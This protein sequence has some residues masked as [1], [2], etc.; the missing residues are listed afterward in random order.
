MNDFGFTA[1]DQVKT[2]YKGLS[3]VVILGAGAS[4]ASVCDNPEKNGKLLPS[5]DNLIDI[6]GLEGM[7]SSNI[8]KYNSRNFELLF[9]SLYEENK[10]SSLIKDLETEVYNYFDSLSLPDTPTIYDYLILSLRSKDIIATFNWD[11]FLWQAFVRNMDFTDNLPKL[12]FLHGNVAV[13]V[14]EEDKSFGPK[15]KLSNKSKKPFLP[16]K[17]L[18][19]ITKKDYA[20]N[21]YIADQWNLL[22]QGLKKPAR[23][24][25]FGYSAP[26]SDVEAIKIMKKAY[27]NP[28]NQRFTQFEIIDI[29][30]RYELADTWNEFI[31]SHHYEVYN[32]FFDSTI[33]RFPRRT[34]EVFW[35]NYMQAK[36]WAPNNPPRVNKLSELWDWYS[37]FLPAEN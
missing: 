13:G 6:I 19:P 10:D 34:G 37:K 12:A 2:V 35:E 30:D 17:L 3:H 11:P 36:W 29:K 5:M 7:L 28:E 14:C 27:G 1:E 33:M 8:K 24:T 25:V 15:Y 26:K 23:V 18:Y 4:I 22:S 9:S 16:T 31:F 21:P 32:D 20:T